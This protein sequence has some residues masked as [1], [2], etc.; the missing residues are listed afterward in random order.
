MQGNA[1]SALPPHPDRL[2]DLSPSPIRIIPFGASV[3]RSSE[4]A[5]GTILTSSSWLPDGRHTAIAL[6]ST[7]Y[8][9]SLVRF[10]PQWRPSTCSTSMVCVGS[11]NCSIVW[12]NQSTPSQPA[13][14]A[15]RR[16]SPNRGS[17]TSPAPH[18][19][20]LD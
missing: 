4:F 13:A 20:Y 3:S 11:F 16:N 19:G 14:I 18:D 15:S 9:F 8:D 17:I 12:P 7:D 6:S 5:E 2:R 10:R 1:H